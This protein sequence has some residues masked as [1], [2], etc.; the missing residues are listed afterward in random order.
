MLFDLEL[1]SPCNATCSF[2]PQSFRGVKR[3]QALMDEE[4]LDKITIPI[5]EELGSVRGI[6][7]VRGEW[8]MIC[9]AHNLAKLCLARAA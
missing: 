1:V 5:E 8:A 6:D 4:V 7:K 9:T 3:K 2:C